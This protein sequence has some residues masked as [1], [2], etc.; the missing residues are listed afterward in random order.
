MFFL[1]IVRKV[2]YLVL[3]LKNEISINNKYIKFYFQQGLLNKNLSVYFCL[4]NRD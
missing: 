3:V 2:N 1:E 4:N